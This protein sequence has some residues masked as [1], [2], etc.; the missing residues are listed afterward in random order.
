[1]R[2]DLSLKAAA[3]SRRH[4]ASWDVEFLEDALPF[5]DRP[6]RHLRYVLA[7]RVGARDGVVGPESVEVNWGEAVVRV[8]LRY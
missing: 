7:E 4:S 6:Q 5:A 2:S 1:M 3:T 8:G